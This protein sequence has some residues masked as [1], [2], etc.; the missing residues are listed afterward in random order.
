MIG[1]TK[2]TKCIELPGAAV[3]VVRIGA[4]PKLFMLHGGD[5]PAA[6][7]PFADKLAESFEIIAPIH[8]GFAGSAIPDHFDDMQDLVFLYLDLIDALDLDDAIMM[9]ISFGGWIAAEIAVMSTARFSK[10][11]L[12]D[13]VGVKVGGREDRDIADIFATR[14][15]ELA[16]LMWHNPANAPNPA[17]MTD[18]EQE[19]VQSNRVA[20]ALYTWQPYMHNPKLTH[21]LH[22]INVPTLVIWGE[23][24]RVV[25]LDYGRAFSSMIPGAE[26]VVIPRAGHSPQVEQPEIFVEY[27]TT[28]AQ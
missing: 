25:T 2:T 8:P 14:P 21:R 5:G 24:D 12:V 22:R 3:D 28:F 9:G 17:D 6:A 18:A 7:M 10:L 15:D 4:G 1:S 23:S 19:I 27:V 11:I 26:I 16:K 20:L 13:S